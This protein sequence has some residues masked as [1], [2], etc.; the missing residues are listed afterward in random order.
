[1][2]DVTAPARR[3]RAQLILVSGLMI[4]VTLLVLVLLLNTVIYTENVATRGIDSD[5]GEAAAFQVTLD[6]EIERI[7]AQQSEYGNTGDWGH[8]EA[9]VTS[10]VDLLVRHYANQSI[11]RGHI[12]DADAD[13]IQGVRVAKQDDEPGGDSIELGK[14]VSRAHEFSISVDNDTLSETD[15]TPFALEAGDWHLEFNR[16]AGGMNLSDS[17]GN[18]CELQDVETVHVDLINETV[19]PN[20]CEDLQLFGDDGVPPASEEAFDVDIQWN[21]TNPRISYV[22]VASGPD[23][24]SDHDS[25]EW[26]IYETI[27]EIT[28]IS[29]ELRFETTRTIEGEVPS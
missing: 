7:V 3:D 23:L 27:V 29:P 22:L 17:E 18:S 9:N 20:G 16:T 21:D 24:E 14:N 8:F 2:A 10:G 4:A 13:L 19:T 5:V 25:A 28:Y 12:A 15:D 26:F 6:E 1:M 11:E